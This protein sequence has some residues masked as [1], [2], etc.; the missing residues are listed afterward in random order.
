MTLTIYMKE[1]RQ[2]PKC[3]EYLADCGPNIMVFR[4]RKLHAMPCDNYGQFL[5]NTVMQNIWNRDIW[6]WQKY[7]E[8]LYFI[9]NEILN[10]MSCFVTFSLETP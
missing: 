5:Q 3:S 8:S 4:C 7:P 1:A 10:D 6:V 2:D 9:R